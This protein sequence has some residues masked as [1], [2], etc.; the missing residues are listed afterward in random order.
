MKT[1]NEITA[2]IVAV[3]SYYDYFEQGGKKVYGRVHI[4]YRLHEGQ[5]YKPL[6]RNPKKEDGIAVLEEN[7]RESLWVQ[8]NEPVYRVLSFGEGKNHGGTTIFVEDS[9]K[10]SC[11]MSKCYFNCL[12]RQEAISYAASMARQL[13]N[14]NSLENLGSGC[15]IYVFCPDAMKF[16]RERMV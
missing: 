16:K 6:S 14:T 5:F 10:K 1:F 15:V 3:V 13:G 12:N 11:S 8:T 2:P 4:P 7:G 9:Y